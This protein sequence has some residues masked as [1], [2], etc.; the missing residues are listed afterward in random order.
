MSRLFQY[1]LCARSSSLLRHNPLLRSWSAPKANYMYK[2]TYCTIYI[3]K[4][5]NYRKKERK[6][7]FLYF[8]E[9]SI[10]GYVKV[11]DTLLTWLY[12]TI[13]LYPLSLGCICISPRILFHCPNPIGYKIKVVKFAMLAIFNSI[14]LSLL[15]AIGYY[16][17][18]LDEMKAFYLKLDESFFTWCWVSCFGPWSTESK[19]R[20]RG[21]WRDWTED[22]RGGDHCFCWTVMHKLFFWFSN[23]ESNSEKV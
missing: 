8:A 6:K 5:I 14:P 4:G 19:G 2:R 9:H 10:W 7:L 21:T 3:W 17:T 12:L 23:E 16:F 13:T 15:A 11:I 22:G 18:T 20:R 1:F